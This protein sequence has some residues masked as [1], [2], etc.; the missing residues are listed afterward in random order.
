MNAVLV[1]GGAGFVGS[2]FV[3]HL[4]QERPGR[5]VVLDSLTVA[6]NIAD[7]ADLDGNDRYTFVR[8]DIR[9][10]ELLRQLFA[11]HGFDAVVN[12]AAESYVDR[13]IIDPEIFVSTNVV[14]TQALLDAARE[15]W[16]LPPEIT[17]DEADAARYSDG[18]RFVQISAAEVYGDHPPEDGFDE[19]APLAPTTPYAASK[20]GADLLVQSYND[21][22]GLPVNIVRC[23]INYGP[24]QFPEK[25]VPKVIDYWSTQRAMPVYGDGRHVRDWIFVGDTCCA[26]GAVLDRGI[27]G[28]SYNVGGDLEHTN[29]AVIN[30][31]LHRLG[32]PLKE[33]EHVHDRP[34]HQR[35]VV[36]DSSKIRSELGWT[37]A[38]LLEDGLD[39]TVSWY[40]ANP[41][42]LRQ[43]TTGA[44]R[45]S[46]REH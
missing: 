34:G 3:H 25:L 13:S 12:F 4:L 6:A 19:N 28:E 15:S 11:D 18:V 41:E 26:I 42:W 35:R 43:M 7:L 24:H 37:P 9:D 40:L 16:R 8:G 29:L 32:V 20:A 17:K 30:A 36:L 2:H 45:R 21:A 33:A 38:H 31:V 23:S 14:G 44:Y 10:R 27:K 46:D 1:T 39:E 5:V 22:F